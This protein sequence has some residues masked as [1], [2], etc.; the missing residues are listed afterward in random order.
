MVIMKNALWKDIFR[1][2]R[3]SKGRFIS[4]ASIIALGVMLFAGVKIA[5]I[6]MKATA[7]KY[8]DDYNLMD[9]RLVSTLGLTDEDVNDIRNIEGV[10]GVEASKT[11]DVTSKVDSDEFVIRVH[12]LPKDDLSDDNENYINR[13]NLIEGHLPTEP[14]ECVIARGNF[15][16]LTLKI[17]DKLNVN[18]GDDSDIKDSLVTNE[19][20]VVGIVETPYY[21]SDQIGSSNIGNGSVKTYMFI[22]ESDFKSEVYTD[23]YVTVEDAKDLDSY[24]DKYFEVTDKVKESIE[25]ISN[26]IIDRRYDE[27]VNEANEEL[28]KG[29][30]EYE[31]KKNE[32]EE[33]LEKA[34]NE[35]D[36]SRNTLAKGEE[37][38]NSKRNEL[39]NSL[40]NGQEEILKA[41]QE[42]NEKESQLNEGI[43]E[44]YSSKESIEQEFIKA[45]SSINDSEVYLEG[46]LS[47]KSSLENMLKG[48]NLSDEEKAS[49][50][51]NINS[52][53][54]II[55]EASDKIN[56]AKSEL[57]NKKDELLKKENELN[58]A[59]TQIEEGKEKINKSKAD[60]EEAKNQGYSQIENAEAEI[61]NGKAKLADGEKELEENKK[62]AEEELLKAKEKLEEAEEKIS[63]IEKPDLY[64]LDRK[65]HYS[66]V[67]YENSANSIDKLSNVFPM[68]F[69]I[70]AA[71][72]C[73]TTMTRMV[74]EQRVNIGTLKALGYDKGSIAKKF[75]VYGLF[76]S[77]IGCI[78]GITLGFTVL[79]LVIFNAYSILYILPKMTYVI[80]IPLAIIVFAVAIGVTTLS[81]YAACRI[82]L[83]E[84]PSM[85]MRPKAP[86]EG[87][88]I[89]LERIPFIW[90]RLN[91]IGKV[92]IRNIFRYKKR[93]LMTVIGIAGSTALLVAGF[94]IK[95][96]IKTVV[97]RQYGDLTQYDISV[98]LNANINNDE[99][100][101]LEDHLG[102]DTK[103]KD[104]IFVKSES[105]EASANEVSKNVNIIVTNDYE[106]FGEFEHLQDRKS[107]ETIILPKDGVAISEKLSKLLDV[108]VGDEIEIIN[109]ND[110]RAKAKVSEV[111][112]HYINH[113]IYI[114]SDYYKN[115]F[116]KTPEEN[117]ILLKVD[118]ENSINDISNSLININGV[119]GVVNNNS[120][121]S[122]F[123]DTI[124]SLDLVILVMI[125]CA[126]T[127]SFIVLYNLT[128]VNISERIRE[129]ATI[130]VL[131]FYDK[132]VSAY[133]FRENILLSVIGR[134]GG[135]LLG[136]VFHK[137][138]MVTVEMDYVMFGR[139]IDIKSFIMASILTIIFSLLVNW[140]M[141]YKLKKVEMVESL[142]SVD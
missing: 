79:P 16:S 126:G 81:T 98:N 77:L 128:N 26:I 57:Q 34:Q 76:A 21:L 20:E 2:I 43:N 53:E 125:F 132:E 49:I 44:F 56:V 7:D 14:G 93:F 3:K 110:N 66:Y 23:I 129:I 31:S 97:S 48:E 86:K 74:D 124:K 107:K 85:L 113:Y 51:V 103:I 55:K 63:E 71:L 109:N 119:V 1:D 131:G 111:V 33:E 80:H 18:S 30:Q 115:I 101:N 67:D 108:K 40:K 100:T 88:R 28:N 36:S 112:E 15:G 92:T 50:E 52:L 104:F 139:T 134:M 47:Q 130:K 6:N 70:V 37:E 133:I 38:L 123:D 95:D 122:S 8:Y 32:V 46:L 54:V 117:S 136:S 83:I 91:F 65:S 82:E 89:L 10:L 22:S 141:Y 68:F 17:G 121:K 41:E 73:L 120:I 137:F 39:E 5:P 102:Q 4:I 135:L 29:K 118:N 19:Y 96:S 45:E 72:V 106:K 114:D 12:S 59:K 25:N 58:L 62:K 11:L 78:I 69:F 27:V 13:L 9:L 99:K 24:D 116:N 90:N 138:I 84:V 42:L 94:G 127:L 87:K 140:A 105:G 35:I 75:I 64:V 61:E 142:K 60:L